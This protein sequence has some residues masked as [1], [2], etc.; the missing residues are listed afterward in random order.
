MKQHD[1]FTFDAPNGAKVNAVVL[2]L[3][4]ESDGFYTPGA[5]YSTFLCYAQNRLF[6]YQEIKVYGETTYKLGKTIVDYAILPDY[7]AILENSDN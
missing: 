7:D 2:D 3:V 4:K 6:L 5:K 1:I